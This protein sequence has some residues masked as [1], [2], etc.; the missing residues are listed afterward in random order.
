MNPSNGLLDV[1]S[2][3]ARITSRTRGVVPVHLYGIPADIPGLRALAKEH[4]LLLME[5]CA[6]AHGAQLNGVPVGGFGF[7]SGWSF[8]PTKNLGAVGDAGAIST[9]DEAVAARL[10]KLRNY[11]QSDR[12]THEEPGMNSRLDP[13]QA[14]ILSVKL[15][16]LPKEIARRQAIADR[17]TEALG[18]HKELTVIPV[19][20][21]GVSS[22]H[23]YPVLTQ[24]PKARTALQD[25]LKA[26]GIQTLVHYPIAMSAQPATEK[27]LGAVPK[28]PAAEA[29]CDRVL[30]LPIHPF[31]TDA[32]VSYVISALTS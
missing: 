24:G 9:N 28:C 8:Y 17:Y 1:A 25:K 2:V 23:L 5:D 18:D 20:E 32:Q 7:A 10:A 6:Q 13:I 29:F 3:K 30:S 27:A 21:G 4:N 14:A 31:L 12:Y 19:L 11:G 22:R 26:A 15:K 16:H